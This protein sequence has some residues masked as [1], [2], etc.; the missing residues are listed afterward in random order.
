MNTKFLAIIPFTLPLIS[1]V[2]GVLAIKSPEN[3]GFILLGSVVGRMLYYFMRKYKLFSPKTHRAT[4]S[5]ILGGEALACMQ[6]AHGGTIPIESQYFTGLGVGFFACA[7]YAG[8]FSCLFA[9]GFIK[10]MRQFE[11]AVA[12]GNLDTKEIDEIE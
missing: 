12:C 6:E 5:A 7:S 11:I 2:I 1:G 4:L 3:Y 8:L 9:L 10:S